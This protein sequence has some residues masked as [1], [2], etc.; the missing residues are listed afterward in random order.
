[1]LI[2]RVG[3][4]CLDVVREHFIEMDMSLVIIEEA[5]AIFNQYQI[6]ISKEDTE[7]VE[8]LR[9]NFTNM[10]NHVSNY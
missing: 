8:S 9:F 7:Q 4:K 10:I 6:D 5:Y 1:M 2:F 3:M